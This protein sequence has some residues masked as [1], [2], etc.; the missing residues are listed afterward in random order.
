MA[1]PLS[2]ELQ[3]G[4]ERDACGTPVRPSRPRSALRGIAVETEWHGAE[5]PLYGATIGTVAYLPNPAAVPSH[6]RSRR[7]KILALT[8]AA[9]SAAT[10]LVLLVGLAPY[11]M[12]GEATLPAPAVVAQGAAVYAASCAGCHGADL[13]GQARQIG[14]Q[15]A[16]AGPQAPALDGSGHAW[17]HS[18]TELRRIVEGGLTGCPG[19]SAAQEMPGFNGK[20]RP[21]AIDAA[22]AFMKTRWPAEL[23]EIQHALGEGQGQVAHGS[24][25]AA[26]C[27]PRCRP[28]V[29]TATAA[30]DL[31]RTGR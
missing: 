26:L 3:V 5:P 7:D 20:L 17:M 31:A 28:A 22:F 13:K 12:H 10:A 14:A 18:D 9:L 19:Q 16:A 11:L 6:D 23:R 27:T 4:T 30:T 25:P 2:K 29:P 24:R 1:E 8:V 21:E 15:P